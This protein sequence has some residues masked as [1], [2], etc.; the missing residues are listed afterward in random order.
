M[1]RSFEVFDFTVGFMA[2]CSVFFSFLSPWG[3]KQ[4]LRKAMWY[5]YLP[6]Y[7]DVHDRARFF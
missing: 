1:K 5:K 6:F 2:C 4:E 7:L 3:C